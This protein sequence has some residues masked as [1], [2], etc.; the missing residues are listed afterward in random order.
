MWDSAGLYAEANYGDFRVAAS[1]GQ[2]AMSVASFLGTSGDVPDAGDA[3][4]ISDFGA[5]GV[6]FTASATDNAAT[7]EFPSN[8]GW[9]KDVSFK[10]HSICS[11]A[12]LFAEDMNSDSMLF[13]YSGLVWSTFRDAR[14]SMSKVVMKIRP[15]GYTPSSEQT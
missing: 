2:Y 8:P 10:G 11:L 6:G 13:D 9:L 14:H 15:N 1:G 12:N 5:P 3:F 7:C 4:G